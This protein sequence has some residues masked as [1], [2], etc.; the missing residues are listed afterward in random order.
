[1]A[2]SDSLLLAG[3]Q[4]TAHLEYNTMIA[5]LD[6]SCCR[7]GPSSSRRCLGEPPQS[8]EVESAT[9]SPPSSVP[10][11]IVL[12]DLDMRYTPEEHELAAEA[13]NLDKTQQCSNCASLMVLVRI[14]EVKYVCICRD[15]NSTGEGVTVH[16]PASDERRQSSKIRQEK[17]TQF[18]EENDWKNDIILYFVPTQWR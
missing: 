15:H 13:I 1:M 10:A 8:T 6:L 9:W 16:P 3:I 11:R 17:V 14:R 5:K 7:A 2:S 12:L 4:L 18:R